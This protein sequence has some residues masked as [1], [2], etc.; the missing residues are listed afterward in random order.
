VRDKGRGDVQFCFDDHQA[1]QKLQKV[2][3]GFLAKVQCPLC[4]SP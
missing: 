1:F 3:L 4:N 2:P